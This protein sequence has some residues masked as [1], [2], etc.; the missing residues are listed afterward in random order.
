MTIHVGHQVFKDTDGNW[1]KHKLTETPGCILIQSAKCCVEVH[2]YYTVY[3]D[4]NHKKVRVYDS[5]WLVQEWT[6]KKWKDLGFWN[7]ALTAEELDNG[8]KVTRTGETT[9]GTLTL[10]YIQRDASPLKHKITWTNK[11]GKEKTVRIVLAWSGIVGT[12]IRTLNRK[13]Y[14]APITVNTGLFIFGD[15]KDIINENLLE[16]FN[17]GTLA[18]V[19]IDVHVQGLKADF[20]FE[21]FT[22]APNDNV[23]IDP[24]TFTN[25]DPTEDGDIVYKQ[26]SNTYVRLDN[27]PTIR[28]KY[29]QVYV[30]EAV[31]HHYFRSYVEWDISAIPDAATIDLVKFQY[32]GYQNAPIDSASIH[33]MANRPSTSIDSVVWADCADGTA[34]LSLSAIF[35][36]IVPFPGPYEREVGGVAVPWDTDPKTDLQ[37]QL[38]DNWFA[39]GFINEELTDNDEDSIVSEEGYVEPKPTLYVEYTYV[40]PPVVWGGSAL[41]QVQMAK[42]ILGL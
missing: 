13:Q 18:P 37:N 16:Q 26:N 42:V 41:P 5:R 14:S 35:P 22:V 38:V 39:L 7:P 17:D 1:K 10:E 6:G 11:S 12:K 31:D 28:F 25:D 27:F 36:E 15:G 23:I 2:P 20:E 19:T 33:H 8:L 29:D 32:A 9:N 4:V 3:Y 34:Y 21:E 24:D 40:P 30:K